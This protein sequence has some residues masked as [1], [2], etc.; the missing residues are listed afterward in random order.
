MMLR[1]GIE[2]LAKLQGD[3]ALLKENKQYVLSNRMGSE[4][5]IYDPYEGKIKVG[6]HHLTDEEIDEDVG[7]NWYIYEIKNI[8]GWNIREPIKGK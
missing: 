5:I 3:A 6:D 1:T 8:N 7:D 4:D 2:R